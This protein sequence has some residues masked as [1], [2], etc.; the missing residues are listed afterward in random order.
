MRRDE[1]KLFAILGTI[2]LLIVGGIVFFSTNATPFY[3]SEWNFGEPVG[4]EGFGVVFS[5]SKG[6][7]H[8]TTPTDSNDTTDPGDTGN[9]EDGGDTGEPEVGGDTGDPEGGGDS[10]DPTLSLDAIP[11]LLKRGDSTILEWSSQS[12]TS[13]TLTGDNGDSWSGTSGSETSSPIEARTVFTLRCEG[14]SGPV[15][16]SVIVNV[17]PQFEEF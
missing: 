8:P 3:S 5:A 4:N 10:G 14:D 16:T 11:T 2:V 17:V 15:S 9:P 13:C 6:S 12:A 1:K 7:P